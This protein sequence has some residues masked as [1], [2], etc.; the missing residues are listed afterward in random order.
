MDR[1]RQR[2]LC[3]PAPFCSSGE[4]KLLA[5]SEKIN[6]LIDLHGVSGLPAADK[7]AP[8]VIVAGALL[9][10]GVTGAKKTDHATDLDR[11]VL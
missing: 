8:G 5:E 7:G 11:V 2:R 10:T 3:N 9:M 4:V 6:D 1:I